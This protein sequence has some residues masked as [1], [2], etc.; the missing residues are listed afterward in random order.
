MKTGDWYKD[1]TGEKFGKLTAIKFVER[2]DDKTYWLFK[3]DCG[4]EV[5]KNMG[6]AGNGTNSCGC[7]KKEQDIKNLNLDKSFSKGLYD[8]KLY[9]VWQS[10]R[11]RCYNSNNH[12]Y[13]DYGERGVRI[14]DKWLGENGFI[15][16][17]DWSLE[18]GYK[19]KLTIDRIEVNGNYE[20]DNCRWATMKEQGNNRRNNTSITIKG[21]T[22]N[23]GEWCSIFNI[24]RKTVSTRIHRG[25]T[26]LEAITYIINKLNNKNGSGINV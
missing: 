19:E 14:C 3:C 6:S 26:P 9:S 2:K 25:E 22:K 7:L 8:H 16:F 21:E 4:N 11:D 1:I 23:L 5:I 13:K 17:Y 12:A 20:P 18:N 10:M 15:N 24:N